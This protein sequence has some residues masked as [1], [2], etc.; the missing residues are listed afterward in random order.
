M[1]TCCPGRLV[2]EWMM[3]CCWSVTR[4]ARTVRNPPREF[5]LR[6]TG[7]A[8]PTRPHPGPLAPP[9][10]VVRSARVA[11]SV[12]SARAG[13]RSR[14]CL[15]R[16]VQ[17]DELNVRTYLEARFG[18]SARILGISR[19]MCGACGSLSATMNASWASS[20][21]CGGPRQP[22]IRSLTRQRVLRRMNHVSCVCC[23]DDGAAGVGQ[24]DHHSR[25]GQR[26]GRA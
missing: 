5:T 14:S 7:L 26:A 11:Q 8:L 19:S 10:A 9:H 12:V 22:E 16:G 21:L 23:V 25:S 1:R 4:A 6:V 3:V 2:D 17:L 18:G 24:V 15:K 20:I 13:T